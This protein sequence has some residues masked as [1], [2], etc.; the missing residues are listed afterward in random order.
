[1]SPCDGLLKV[2]PISEG[3]ILPV[4]Q[5]KFTISDLLVDKELAK[6]F[7]GGYCLVY[8]WKLEQLNNKEQT[9]K[10]ALLICELLLELKFINFGIELLS[11]FRVFINNIAVFLHV[12]GHFSNRI[13]YID[14]T[15]N[16][17]I[18]RICNVIHSLRY[19]I[20]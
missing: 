17:F 8:R 7:D 16:T 3:L 1:M 2:Y 10:P 5:S 11:N 15:L 20:H 6:Q 12:T 14:N 9:L 4:K 18:Y 19:N 13:S